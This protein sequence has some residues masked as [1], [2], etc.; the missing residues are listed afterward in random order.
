M[1]YKLPDP[2]W[3][4]QQKRWEVPEVVIMPE[5]GESLVDLAGQIAHASIEL[6]PRASGTG[7]LFTLFAHEEALITEKDLCELRAKA[8]KTGRINIDYWKGRP[9]KLLLKV[10][11]DHI[12][13]SLNWWADR[14]DTNETNTI[15][16]FAVTSLEEV[17]ALASTMP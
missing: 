16:D 9:V 13:I 12:A 14:W 7:S 3:V 6:S 10:K 11:E 17:L 2:A 1:K 8:A 5:S 4:G 15:P